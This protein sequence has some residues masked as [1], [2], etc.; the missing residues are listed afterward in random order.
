MYTYICMCVNIDLDLR[1]VAIR[2]SL[3]MCVHIYTCVYLHVYRYIYIYIYKRIRTCVCVRIWIYMYIYTYAH[4]YPS[5]RATDRLAKTINTR[6][7]YRPTLSPR[8]A[9]IRAPF[10]T[11]HTHSILR[12]N[13]PPYSTTRTHC[14]PAQ[15]GAR[16]RRIYMPSGRCVRVCVCGVCVCTCVCVYVSVCACACVCVR[17]HAFARALTKSYHMYKLGPLSISSNNTVPEQT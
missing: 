17:V 5:Q 10:P 1:T 4:M 12:T 9:P 8:H 15:C 2:S 16:V 11:T 7:I 3:P 6:C 14:A 13:T